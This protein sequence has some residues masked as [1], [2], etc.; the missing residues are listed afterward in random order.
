M[1]RKQ[2]LANA[3]EVLGKLRPVIS[4][5]KMLQTYGAS[6]KTKIAFSTEVLFRD[7]CHFITHCFAV[8]Q[9]G[10]VCNERRACYAHVSYCECNG[11][12]DDAERNAG[13]CYQENPTR[14][15][16]AGNRY[17]LLENRNHDT[18]GF[19]FSCGHS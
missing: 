18:H 13:R 16:F 3:E 15:M 19:M 12:T 9:S 8:S 11:A 2:V 17:S 5:P 1:K 7:I 6:I 4:L 14:W 10:D